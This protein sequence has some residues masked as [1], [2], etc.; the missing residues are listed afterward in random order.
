LGD[1]EAAI[2]RKWAPIVVGFGL[3]LL[4][5]GAVMHA[6]V[7]LG[8]VEYSCEVPS[9]P[10]TKMTYRIDPVEAIGWWLIIGGFICV[11]L[12]IFIHVMSYV[13]D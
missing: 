5:C 13:I 3:I 12:G 2:P 9:W 4:V 8:W 1:E 7:S 6:V 11:V 10:F